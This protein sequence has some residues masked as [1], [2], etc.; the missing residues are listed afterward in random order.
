MTEGLVCDAGVSDTGNWKPGSLLHQIEKITRKPCCAR[1]IARFMVPYGA[2]AWV[3]VFQTRKS[4]RRDSKE[5]TKP[6]VFAQPT[7][8]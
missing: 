5:I 6:A 4:L 8:L 7:A 2:V 1:C 3:Q